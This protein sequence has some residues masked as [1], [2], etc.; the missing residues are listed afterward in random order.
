MECKNIFFEIKDDI[1]LVKMNRPEAL[2]AL[3]L[4]TLKELQF[5][6]AEHLPK[7]NLRAVLLTGEGKSFVAGADIK[8][9]AS[10]SERQSK[11]FSLLGQRVFQIIENFDCPVIAVVNGF[12]LGGG[13]EL[14]LACDFRVVSSKAKFGQPEVNL[15]II[16]GFGGTQ[17]LARLVGNGKAKQL[18]YTGALIS[19]EEAYRIGLAEEI[20]SP[21]ELLEKSWE[22]A[23]TIAS[24][25]PVAVKL[26]KQAINMGM[27]MDLSRAL[28]LE[29]HL[30]SLS[31]ITEDSKEGIQA[32]VEKREAQ[33]K[34]R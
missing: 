26:C 23:K 2:N 22:L 19:G 31:F 11:E 25:A 30:F 21:E 6:F 14:A 27:N 28:D 12:A 7:E 24:K 9:M 29:A 15:G 34:G 10:M 20:F 1:A 17:R 18:I 16:P 32:F 8:G 5:L 33:F 4:E 3:N 13:C